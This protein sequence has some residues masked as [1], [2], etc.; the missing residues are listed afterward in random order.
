MEGKAKI[1]SKLTSFTHCYG[2][3]IH[4]RTA[5]SKV[6]NSV[7]VPGRGIQ[8]TSHEHRW[9]HVPHHEAIFGG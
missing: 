3:A 7:Q 6:E 4:S 1:N 2:K 9:A 8:K 5:T